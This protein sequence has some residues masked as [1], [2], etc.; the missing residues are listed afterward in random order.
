[1]STDVVAVGADRQPRRH[2][3]VGVLGSKEAWRILTSPA[4]PLLLCYLV[5]VLGLGTITGSDEAYVHS[6]ASWAELTGYLALLI[7][8]PITFVATHLVATSARRSGSDRLLTATP[9]DPRR[10]DLALC[11]GVLVGPTAAGLVLACVSAWLTSGAE[12]SA[13]A[14]LDIDRWAWTDVAQVPAI[15]LGAGI[16]AVVVARWV[17]A[18]GSLLL[19][20]VALIFGTG[21]MV[22][23]EGA[24]AVLP[25]F[26]PYVAIDWWSSAAW[27]RGGSPV[28]HLAYLFALSGLGVC[29]VALRQP[30]HRSRWL[31]IGAVACAAVVT[32]G[33]LQ[34]P[35][36]AFGQ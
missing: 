18:P 6:R 30:G 29:A 22:S 24:T 36:S 27:T 3:A 19:A 32:T 23:A 34:L 11:L 35:A 16:L 25:W 1:M 8:G 10:R 12:T 4:V 33:L 21:W 26:A 9:L 2:R 14:N 5:L 17:P 28:W 15:V 7:A 31:V 20:F 13:A